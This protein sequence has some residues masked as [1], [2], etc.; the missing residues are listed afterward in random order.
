MM[1]F[2]MTAINSMNGYTLWHCVW[3]GWHALFTLS[4]SLSLCARLST[5]CSYTMT[6]SFYSSLHA[7]FEIFIFDIASPL[8]KRRAFFT[9]SFE[10]VISI[11]RGDFIGKMHFPVRYSVSQ[12]SVA[13]IAQH[14][15]ELNL[16]SFLSIVQWKVEVQCSLFV[17]LMDIIICRY[18]Q[19]YGW[20]KCFA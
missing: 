10:F 19:N 4:F 15:Y 5:L 9:L 13:S 8:L 1:E 14:E 16:D 12:K 6:A 3:W 2:Q 17:T 7:M 18:R 11:V 20:G